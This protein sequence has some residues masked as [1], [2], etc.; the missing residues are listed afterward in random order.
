MG[1][2]FGALPVLRLLTR[3]D[4]CDRKALWP[5]TRASGRPASTVAAP[6]ARRVVPSPVKEV[7]ALEFG[8]AMWEAGYVATPELVDIS[9]VAVGIGRPLLLE[10]PAGAGKTAFAQALAQVLHRPLIRL[11]CYEGIDAAQAL[12]DWNYARQ[13]AD[14]AQHRERDPFQPD[15]LLPRPLLRALLEPQGAVVL[16]DD[17]DRADEAFEALLLEV[18]GEQQISIPEYGTVRAQG[19]VQA[20]LTSNRTRPLSDALRRRCLY[21]R[22]EWPDPEREV[23][24]LRRHLPDARQDV[25]ALVARMMERLRSWDLVKPPGVGESLDLVRAMD[26]LGVLSL[27]AAALRRLLGAVIKDARDWDAVVG[28]LEELLDAG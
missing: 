27:D 16:V 9:R 18:L 23:A 8:A 21:Q 11:Q 12:Y 2:G 10:G 20:V 25:L 14:L 3:T 13:L 15:Y 6:I 19:P 7:D 28:R 24:I 5:P 4:R 1:A 22:L 17:V 26:S